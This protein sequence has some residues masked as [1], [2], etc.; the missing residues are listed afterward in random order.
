[1]TAAREIG[2]TMNDER[3]NEL[4][5]LRRDWADG[6]AIAQID[7]QLCATRREG[8]HRSPVLRAESATVLRQKII[9]DFAAHGMPRG[10]RADGYRNGITS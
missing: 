2:N 7:G 6:Y 4:A 5:A 10:L 8:H 1:M 9:A 3:P